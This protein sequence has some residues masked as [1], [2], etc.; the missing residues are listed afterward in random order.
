MTSFLV[1]RRESYEMVSRTI[2]ILSIDSV[3]R[4]NYSKLMRGESVSVFDD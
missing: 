2:P 4:N 3:V 1:C